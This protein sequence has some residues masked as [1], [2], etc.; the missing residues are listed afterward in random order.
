M[1][2]AIFNGRCWSRL[3]TGG[4]GGGGE[5]CWSRFLTGGVA[6]DCWRIIISSSLGASLGPPP[7]WAPRIRLLYPPF[8][9]PLPIVTFICMKNDQKHIKNVET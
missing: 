8:S 9:A 3:L 6:R 1:L 7:S 4:G 5:G 2:V